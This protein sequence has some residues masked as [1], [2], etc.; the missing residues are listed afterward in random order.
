MSSKHVKTDPGSNLKKRTGV[1]LAFSALGNWANMLIGM[2]SLVVLSRILGPQPYGEFA[3]LLACL[4][5][6]MVILT[7]SLNESIIQHPKLEE[8]H[9]DTTFAVAMFGAFALLGI[10]FVGSSELLSALNAQSLQWPLF[11]L[12]AILPLEAAATV[13]SGLLIRRLEY[14][15]F[16]K[17]DVASSVIAVTASIGAALVTV[18]I[19]PLIIGEVSR[20]IIRLAM[21]SYYSRWRPGLQ[22]ESRYFKDLLGFNGSISAIAVLQVFTNEAPRL[23]IGSSLGLIALSFFNLAMRVRDQLKAALVTPFGAVSFAVSSEMSRT[24]TEARHLIIAGIKLSSLFAYPAF[25]GMAVVAPIAVPLVFGNQWADAVIPIQ[26]ASLIALRAPSSSMNSGIMKGYGKPNFVLLGQAVNVVLIGL[27]LVFLLPYG[28]EAT[29]WGLLVQQFLHWLL[30]AWLVKILT[31][32]EFHL[33]LFA[34]WKSLI[35]SLVMVVGVFWVQNS[36]IETLPNWLVLTLAISFGATIFVAMM[37]LLSRGILTEARNLL[38][39]GPTKTTKPSFDK[40]IAL[41]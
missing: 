34:G 11:A 5:I 27:V 21:I 8:G 16:A 12:L 23:A 28:L 1:A 39:W 4:A 19:W 35:S 3:L 2:V 40:I 6:P 41:L 22:I 37:S 38:P 18:S 15:A 26:I 13:P 36:L 17:I 14:A 29:M 10:L 31:R 9:L 7:V 32:V 24:D 20:K 30:T 25:L 33:Q